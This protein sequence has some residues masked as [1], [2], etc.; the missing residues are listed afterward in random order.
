M[1]VMAAIQTIGV[2]PREA[3]ARR[4]HT[5]PQR[6]RG[7]GTFA[8]I[9]KCW[10]PWKV[11]LYHTVEERDRAWEASQC[12]SCATAHCSPLEHVKGRLADKD[13]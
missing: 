2:D 11:N 3:L 4:F 10:T 8:L 12:S 7:N 6:I 13:E 5:S 1:K 9:F